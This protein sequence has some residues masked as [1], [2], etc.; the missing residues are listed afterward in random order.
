MIYPV[1][2]S[3]ISNNM[4]VYLGIIGIIVALY[5]IKVE[6]NVHKAGFKAMCD[7]NDHVSCSRVLSSPYA[8]M[9]KMTFGLADDHPLNVPN[10]Y[11]GLLFYVAVVI[12]NFVY[13]P[14]QEL[15]LLI[16]SAVS[17][18]ACVALAYIL[19]FKLKDFC[20]VCVATYF[21]NMGIFYYAYYEFM[22][23]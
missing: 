10:T 1:I 18:C 23:S 2:N 16:V 12:Y 19:Y 6:Q 15:L 4:L 20:V 7:I 22:N 11:Y 14:Y 8:K 9:M 13:V 5:A 17:L 21:I 3:N